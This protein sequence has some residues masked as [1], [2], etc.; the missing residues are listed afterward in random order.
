MDLSFISI[1]NNSNLNKNISR[2]YKIIKKVDK[3][4]NSMDSRISDK[5]MDNVSKSF[6][7]N[8]NKS[9]Y[10]LKGLIYN[11]IFQNGSMKNLHKLILKQN[12]IYNNPLDKSH[13]SHNSFYK[14][15][16]NS[17]DNIKSYMNK[18]NNYNKKNYFFNNMFN[19]FC[20]KLNLNKHPYFNQ[21]SKSKRSIDEFIKLSSSKN[22][23]NSIKK[24]LNFNYMSNKP[25]K[26]DSNLLNI[27][28]LKYSDFKK[29]IK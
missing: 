8:E 11:K 16:N 20:Y 21:N 19:M 29:N 24:S 9:K 1:M 6:L 22:Y 5:S 18:N 23:C 17:I 4:S 13:N 28:N 25:I 2:T 3:L 12:L 14:K 10:L 15:K 26:K 27:N 7:N